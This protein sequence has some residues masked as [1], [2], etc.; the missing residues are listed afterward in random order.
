MPIK[1]VL[2]FHY[3]VSERDGSH[4]HTREFEAAFGRLC[5]ERGVTFKVFFPGLVDHERREPRWYAWLR[6]QLARFYLRDLKLLL[7]QW[8]RMRQERRVLRAERPDI[9]LTRY[10][11][12]TLSII[13]A[14]RKEGIPVVIEI[15]SPV[16]DEQDHIY[17]Q[18]PWFKRLFSNENALRLADGAF[19]VSEEISRPLREALKLART[20][21]TIPNGVDISR[22][23]PHLPGG[24]V[25]AKHAIGADRVVIGFVGSFAP[26]HGLDLLVD[27]F[28]RLLAEGLPVHLLLVGQVSA[29]WQRLV[30]RVRGPGLAPHVTVSGF[31]PPAEIPAYLAA[32]DVLALPDTAY[33]C[34]PLKL[35]EYM[36]MARPTVAVR[37]GPVAAMLADGIEG[38]LFPKGDQAAL[39]EALRDLAVDPQARQRLGAAARSRM[40]QEFTWRH[41]AE[42]IMALLEAVHRGA[43]PIKA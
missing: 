24:P 14:C 33:Y 40:E 29:Q 32:M 30:D 37:T 23:D 5:A 41:N 18:L 31:V 8:R 15:N 26:W 13:W 16:H 34:S 35:F 4:V 36:A 10:E 2:Y 19:T 7:I 11:N 3:Q 27:A 1:K 9:V 43:K 25:R 22:F 17:R 12:D 28:E 38:R 39:T 42:R 6:H 21:A 20:V